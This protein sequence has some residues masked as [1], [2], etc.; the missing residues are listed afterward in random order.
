MGSS[1][2]QKIVLVTRPTTFQDVVARHATASQ[3]EFLMVRA[4]Q[5]APRASK[6]A[7]IAE[8]ARQDQALAELARDA[9]QQLEEEDQTYDAMKAQL[10]N[11]LA[12]FAPVHVLDRK[13][14]PSY[15][16]GPQDVVVTLGQD[17]LVANTAK[18]A[19]GRPIVAV[20]PDPRRIDGILLPFTVDETPLVVRRALRGEAPVRQVTLAEALLNNGQRLLAFNDLFI[21]ARTHVSARY[22]LEFDG[23]SEQQS[24]SGVIVSTGAGSTGWLSSIFNMGAA[25]GRLAGAAGAVKPVKLAWEDARLL[26]VTRE[27]FAS[28]TSGVTVTSGVIEGERELIVESSMS[29]EGVIFSDGVEAD[30]L[31]FSSGSIARIRPSTER[32]MLVA[33]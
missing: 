5:S 33:R 4:K 20:N 22:R 19:L 27:P 17:G 23:Q 10:R 16:F 25:I 24:S 28:K 14:L 31:D 30:F 11:Q 12:D 1:I 18:Y 2:D 32:A 29:K 13:Y 8:Q 6:A 3:A 26:F 9:F 21:G 15:V 7:S